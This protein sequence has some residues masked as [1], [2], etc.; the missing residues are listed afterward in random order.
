MNKIRDEIGENHIFRAENSVHIAGVTGSSPVSPTIKSP[1]KS[2]DGHG[3]ATVA[4]GSF[5][6]EMAPGG[7]MTTIHIPPAAL[8]AGALATLEELDAI[9]GLIGATRVDGELT[10]EQQEFFRR[11]ARA[12]FVAMVKAWPKWLDMDADPGAALILPLAAPSG[13]ITE[14]QDDKA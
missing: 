8:E 9:A 2:M 4:N 7:P 1:I 11:I 13:A 12:A 14:K 5:V 10:P 6:P 3:G